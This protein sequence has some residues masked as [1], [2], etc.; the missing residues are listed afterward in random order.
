MFL[1]IRTFVLRRENSTAWSFYVLPIMLLVT[2][3]VNLFFIITKVCR[4]C[5][6]H[7]CQQ[8]SSRNGSSGSW[9]RVPSGWVMTTYAW[10]QYN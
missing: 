2:V 7:L 4:G 6:D 5:F 8:G 1:V 10:T 3:W 9:P